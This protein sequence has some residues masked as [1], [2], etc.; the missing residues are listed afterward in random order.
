MTTNFNC[1]FDFN[2][3]RKR[4]NAAIDQKIDKLI[5][6]YKNAGIAFVKRARQNRGFG[7]ITHN[8]VSSIGCILI[9]NHEVRFVHFPVSGSG[10]EGAKHGE[11]YAREIAT[12]IDDGEVILICVAGEKY[13]ALVEDKGKDVISGTDLFFQDIL[14]KEINSIR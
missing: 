3:I 9:V 12:L 4:L 8:L 2:A 11:E 14:T 1:N 6:A 13:A 5:L 10:S 7:D